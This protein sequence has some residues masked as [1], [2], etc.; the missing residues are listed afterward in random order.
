MELK[1]EKQYR[2]LLGDDKRVQIMLVGVGGTGSALALSLGRLAY[3][4]RSKGMQIDMTFVD[5]D[6]V[7]AKNVGRQCF[8]PA[9]VDYNKAEC[10]ALRL[11]LAFG[12][13]IVAMP[14][15]FT[16]TLARSWSSSRSSLVLLIGAVDN[17]LAR[18]DLAKAVDEGRGRIWCLDIGNAQYNGQVL[19]GNTADLDRIE[20]FELG[21]CSGLPSPYIQEP[22]L[23]EPEDEPMALSCTDLTLRE[24][25]SLMVNQ[26]AASIA[27]QYCH[28]F[29]VRRELAE[30]ATYFNLQP[31]AAVSKPITTGHLASFV[32]DLNPR[33]SGR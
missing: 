8:C 26:T 25:Q 1:I 20:F 28:Q 15:R 19:I 11:N 16:S 18:R 17:H 32:K 30:F 6:L 29:A 27:A 2:V 13:D 33:K 3:H 9:E 22:A 21:L 14:E 7:E 5:H 12:L 23:L 10:L 4:A 24:E 31:P